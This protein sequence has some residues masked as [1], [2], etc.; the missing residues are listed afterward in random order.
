[1][2]YRAK[3]EDLEN[4]SRTL[5]ERELDMPVVERSDTGVELTGEYHADCNALIAEINRLRAGIAAITEVSPPAFSNLSSIK[6]VA[7]SPT[8][9]IKHVHDLL[10]TGCDS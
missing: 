4:D 8:Q 7:M 2:G 6:V 10:G 5:T 9:L 3:K 1:M